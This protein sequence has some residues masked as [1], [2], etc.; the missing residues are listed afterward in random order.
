MR[1]R[2]ESRGCGKGS[3]IGGLIIMAIGMIFLLDNFN[4]LESRA[5]AR[6]WP[7]LLIIVGVSKLVFRRPLPRGPGELESK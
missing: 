6:W 5:F 1:A 3:V 2:Y 4:V 7:I